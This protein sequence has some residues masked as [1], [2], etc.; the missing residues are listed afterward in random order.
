MTK[1]PKPPSNTP[2]AWV[3]F[4]GGYQ[5]PAAQPR[6]PPSGG[7]SVKVATPSQPDRKPKT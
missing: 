7:S 4:K 6:H 2:G 5:G 3:E 1:T